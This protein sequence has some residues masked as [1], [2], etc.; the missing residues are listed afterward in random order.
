VVVAP[1]VVLAD[2]P[3]GSLDSEAAATILALLCR[4]ASVSRAAVVM[5]THDPRA[6]AHA[7][8]VV[9]VADGAIV[10]T[11]SAPAGPKFA[12]ERWLQ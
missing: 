7:Q 5:V 3:T 1:A 8:R 4:A 2:E 12:S 9:R 10:D 11:I 6:A